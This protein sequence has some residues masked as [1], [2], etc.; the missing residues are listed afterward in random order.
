MLHG[1]DKFYM[2]AIKKAPLI[3]KQAALFKNR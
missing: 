3:A 1:V 2:A